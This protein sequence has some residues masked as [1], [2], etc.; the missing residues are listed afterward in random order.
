MTRIRAADHIPY[1]AG[2]PP[3]EGERPGLSEYKTVRNAFRVSVLLGLAGAVLGPLPA[4]GVPVYRVQIENFSVGGPTEPVLDLSTPNGVIGARGHV[5]DVDL[6]A[7]FRTKRSLGVAEASGGKLSAFASASYGLSE[8]MV[9]PNPFDRVNARTTASV[10][11]DDLLIEGAPGPV[12]TRLNLR[13]SGGLQATAGSGGDLG[14]A[15]VQARARIDGVN[16]LT[17]HKTIQD[18]GFGAAL[19]SESG[20]FVGTVNP[21]AGIF[22]TDTFTVQANE[23]FGLE[24]WIQVSAEAGAPFSEFSVVTAGA[25]YG[26][27]FGF[28]EGIPVFDLAPGYTAS[29]LGAGIV[30]NQF[31]PE[32]GALTLIVTGLFG[33]AVRSGGERRDRAR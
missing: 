28:A 5:G 10:I 27:T 33:I 16:V 12:T 25:D 29:S 24:L 6:G 9:G 17:G 19:V 13:L 14:T 1:E 30:D 4:A 23:F 32:P 8:D 3:P 21:H 20:L 31:V 2:E 18:A 22:Q 26:R 15:T 11:F 7:A